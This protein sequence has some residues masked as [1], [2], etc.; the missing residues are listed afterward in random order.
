VFDV[1]VQLEHGAPAGDLLVAAPDPEA[2]RAAFH[3]LIDVGHVVTDGAESIDEL[4][5]ARLTPQGRD[6]VAALRA[7]ND[8]LTR[9]SPAADHASSR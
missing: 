1:L 9:S 2:V 5:S 3:C 6:L 4:D 8:Y 7:Y